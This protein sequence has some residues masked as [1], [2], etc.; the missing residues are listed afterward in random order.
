MRVTILYNDVPPGAPPDER[1]VLDQVAAIGQALQASGQETRVLPVGLDL[2]RVRGALSAARPDCVFNLVESL[3]GDDR[4]ILFAPALLEHMGI[5]YTGAPLGAVLMTTNKVV[6]KR[7]M[8]DAALPTPPWCAPGDPEKSSDDLA[9]GRVILKPVWDHG[10]RALDEDDVVTVDSGEELRERLARRGA[11]D[12]RYA[13]RYVAG[14]EFNLALL[15]GPAGRVEA[16]P[17]AE[18]LFRGWAEGRPRVVGYRA[19]WVPDSFEYRNTVRRFDFDATDRPLLAELDRLARECWHSFG[20]RGWAR[21]DFRVEADGTPWILEA[22]ANPCLAP[23][24][25]FAAALER[26]EIPFAAAIERIVAD[27]VRGASAESP[28]GASR[29]VEYSS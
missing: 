19:K 25:G 4:G 26:A 12:E 15:A 1:D 13:E 23:D 20:L 17:P 2:E 18:M 24:A 7:L 29:P 6:A 21:I 28:G 9:P 3:G 11:E 14:R 5:P 16:L 27:A 10:S 22:N 8:R